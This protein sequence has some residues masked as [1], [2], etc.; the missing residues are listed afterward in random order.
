M[1]DQASGR[2]KDLMGEMIARLKRDLL[3]ARNRLDAIR[4]VP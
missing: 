3:V 1:V 2:G 4:W